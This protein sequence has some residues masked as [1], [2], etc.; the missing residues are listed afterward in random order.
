MQKS[1]LPGRTTWKVMQRNVWED[2]ANF[3]INDKSR[4]TMTLQEISKTE[5]QHQRSSVHFWKSHVC[6]NKLD[7]QETRFSITQL[8]R[9][10][11]HF[12]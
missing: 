5:N 10:G 3:R 1:Y 2:I 6:A 7:V 8:H 9:S 11:N 12:S 4:N